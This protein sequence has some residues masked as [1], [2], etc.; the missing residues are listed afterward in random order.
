MDVTHFMVRTKFLSLVNASITVGIDGVHFNIRMV[1]DLFGPAVVN[2]PKVSGSFVIS[3][4]S[5]SSVTY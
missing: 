5:N 1:E 2:A 4:N 3:S